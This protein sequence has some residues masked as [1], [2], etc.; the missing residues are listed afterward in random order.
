M[1]KMLSLAMALC[2]VILLCACGSEKASAGSSDLTVSVMVLNGTTGFG[3]AKLMADAQ[4]GTAKQPYSFS[5]ETDASNITAALVNGSCDIA[6][7]P[8]NAAAA[9]YN[10]SEGS[11]RCI[12]LNT[13]GVLYLV[14]NS[15]RED[16]QS[17]ADLEGRTVYAPAQNPGFIFSAICQK[18]GINVTVDNRYAQPADLRTALAA[19][20]VSL[21]VLP[22]P[23]VTIAESAN[24]ALVT[25]LDLTQ[26]WDSLYPAGTLVQGC[27]VVRRAFAEA[28]PEALS[29][30]LEEY[31]ASVDYVTAHPDEAAEMIV[32]AG[33]FPQAGV[34]Q[35]AIPN[36]NLCFLTGEEMKNA[37]SG[38]LTAMYEV[39]PASVGGAIP[40]DN[41]Y[42]L[43]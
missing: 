43:G 27:A 9:L 7:L 15:E 35:A 22:E 37:L 41:F 10:K 17:L 39:A 24:E 25:A 29:A 16:I 26:A 14:E 28:H 8:T 31:G 30:F 2:M 1:K 21:A 32:S 11:V 20:E 38:F 3:M 23:M 4:A 34:A 12:A 33:I 6:A 42:Y 5:V 36:C 19:G 13:R 18:A 40:G